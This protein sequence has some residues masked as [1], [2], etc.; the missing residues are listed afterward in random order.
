[1]IVSYSGGS[2]QLTS[3]SS[4]LEGDILLSSETRQA[5]RSAMDLMEL[6]GGAEGEDLVLPDDTI[7]ELTRFGK[8]LFQVKLSRSLVS[9]WLDAELHNYLDYSSLKT[10]RSRQEMSSW[11]S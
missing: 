2:I 7:K 11:Q 3:P 6:V 8:P 9:R 10:M 4:D 1:V 5:L